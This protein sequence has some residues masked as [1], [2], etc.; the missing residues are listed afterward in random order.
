MNQSSALR[1]EDLTESAA[2][3]AD[4]SLIV[5][6]RFVEAADI[7]LHIYVRGL[8]PASLRAF[9]P[10]HVLDYKEVRLR[11][12]PTSSAISRAEEVM[13][14][15]L[16]DYVKDEDRRVLLGKW[17]MCLAAPHIAGSFRDFCKKTGAN[18]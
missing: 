18:S 7:L 11:Y 17:S 6:A 12:K 13:Y 3:I 10:E 2:M 8:R 9:W 4:A 1:L 15:W 5:R 14:R 16:L